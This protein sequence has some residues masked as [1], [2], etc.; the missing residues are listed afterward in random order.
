M[1]FTG[2]LEIPRKEAAALATDIGF[3][4][5]ANVTK[6]TTMLVVGDQDVLKLAGHAKSSKHRRAEDLMSNGQPIRI[7]QES[8]FRELV[9]VVRAGSA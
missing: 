4:V 7:L 3:T 8:D 2:A 6:Q 9:I 1:A 5:G